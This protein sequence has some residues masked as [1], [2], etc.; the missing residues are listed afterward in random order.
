MLEYKNELDKAFHALADGTRRGILERLSHG[1][2]SVSELGKPY[3]ASLAAIHQ[4]V[5]VLENSG[6]IVTEKHGRVRECRIAGA[7]VLRVE[8]WLSARRQLWEDRFDH[9]GKLIETQADQT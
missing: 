5:Q 1:P 7:A 8:N 4:H 2:A 3:A 9:L 6:L